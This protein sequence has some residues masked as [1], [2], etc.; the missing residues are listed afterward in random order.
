MGCGTFWQMTQPLET[1]IIR[2]VAETISCSGVPAT[3]VKHI[4]FSTMDKNLR[5]LHPDFSRTI[6]GELGL[7]NCV[8]IFISMQQCGSS[9]AAVNH[10]WGMFAG[11][12][13]SQIGR[14]HV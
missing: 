3:A 9:L 11:E 14:A 2:C 12:P 6:L 13:E 5:H 8:P 4:V 7:V 1:Y 10:A